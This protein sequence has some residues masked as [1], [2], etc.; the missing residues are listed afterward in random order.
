MTDTNKNTEKKL[1]T[2]AN[3][4]LV[5]D[6]IKM[7]SKEVTS[8]STVGLTNLDTNKPMGKYSLEATHKLDK[9][10]VVK[11]YKTKK[12]RK[13]LVGLPP[14]AATLM[15]F[16]IMQLKP[17]Q[18]FLYINRKRYMKEANV[19]LNTFKTAIDDLMARDVIAKIEG[20]PDFYWINPT[21][22]FCGNRLKKYNIN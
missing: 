3:P 18:D 14:R 20:C 7:E 12:N 13:K 6:H 22:L 21:V 16:I 11:M 2:W 1:S 15:L 9:A 17:S 8:S 5:S 10:D 19:S 4:F